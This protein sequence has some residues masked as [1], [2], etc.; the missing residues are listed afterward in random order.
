MT[1]LNWPYTGITRVKG[2]PQDQ[3]THRGSWRKR[4][5]GWI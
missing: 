1:P 5:P 2:E 4:C 3:G